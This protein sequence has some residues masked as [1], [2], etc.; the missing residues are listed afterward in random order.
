MASKIAWI[1]IIT[2]IGAEVEVCTVISWL[3]AV[4]VEEAT[5]EREVADT[6]ADPGHIIE[7]S[8]S[9]ENFLYGGS[10]M[11]EGARNSGIL[12]ATRL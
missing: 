9:H 7:A 8:A 5:A 4:V 3:P 2:T 1:P 6:I 12:W 11:S 10:L